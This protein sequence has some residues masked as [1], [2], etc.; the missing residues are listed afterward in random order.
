MGETRH[1]PGRVGR[2][3][4]LRAAIRGLAIS[5][6]LG[7]ACQIGLPDALAV[8]DSVG[9]A[10][11][12]DRLG[13]HRGAFHRLVRTFAA[14]GV[15]TID[16]QGMDTHTDASRELRVCRHRRLCGACGYAERPGFGLESACSPPPGHSA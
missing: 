1:S 6:M 16:A 13:S 8:R 11:L 3:T 10:E 5:Q 12:A 4:T 9:I 15:F 2:E 7:S 14:L